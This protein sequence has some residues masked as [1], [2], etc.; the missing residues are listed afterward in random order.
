MRPAAG[1]EVVCADIRR[2]GAVDDAAEGCAAIV[3]LAGIPTEG[4][5]EEL[6]D[7]NIRGTYHV[8]EAARR[9]ETCRRV[10]LASTNHVTGFYPTDQV[11]SGDA[12]P[13]PDG[14]YGASKAY[15]EALGRLYHDKHGLQ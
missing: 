5:F 12:P 9:S 7:S 3:H 4:G 10:V 13:R 11:I 14:L 1:E 8:L 2:V 15:A 6:L